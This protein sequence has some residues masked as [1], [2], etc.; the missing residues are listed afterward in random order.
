MKAK[1]DK[2]MLIKHRFWI[3]LGITVPLVLGAVFVLITTVS[4]EID[5]YRKKAE[6]MHNELRKS[7][8]QA[9]P[10]V[11]EV[12][13]KI[14]RDW[15]T[16]ETN[17]HK[18]AFDAQAH[19][20]TW[21]LAVED[22]FD[23]QNGRFAVDVKIADKAPGAKDSWPADSDELYH[24]MVQSNDEDFI[25]VDGRNGLWKFYRTFN[26]KLSS[27]QGGDKQPQ[28]FHIGTGK[29]VTVTYYKS[30]YFYD[31]LTDNER[32]VYAGSYKTQIHPILQIVDPVDTKGN[33]TVQFNGWLYRPD[34][35][36]PPNSK[37]FTYVPQDWNID[38]FIYEEAWMAQEDLWI[39]RELFRMI[40]AANDDV[41]I[42]K[43]A[44][45]EGKKPALFTNPNFELKF[46][47][48]EDGRF[49][50]TAKN[51]L[52]RRQ[53]LDVHFRVKF[54]KSP[55]LDLSSETIL[56]DGEPLD[57]AGGKRASITKEIPLEPGRIQRTG[58]YG[59]EQVLT[60]ETAPV[61]RIDHVAIGL[62]AGQIAH[63]HK[64][65]PQGSK[66][67]RKEEKKEEAQVDGPMG[68]LPM[69][70][71]S[72]FGAGGEQGQAQVKL[73]VNGV[74]FDRYLEVS[75]QSR[76]LPVGLSLIVDQDHIGRV[77]TAFN[78]SKLRF[79]TMQVLLNRYPGSMRPQL[80]G[81][82]GD[83]GGNFNEDDVTPMLPMGNVPSNVPMIGPRGYGSSLGPMGGGSAIGP[84]RGGSSLGPPKGGSSLGPP[85]G[86]SGGGQPLM[87][88]AP[89]FG[90]GNQGL[91]AGA[92]AFLA[93]NE[94]LENNVEVVI[95]GIV[96]LY[97][98]YPKRK[99][100]VS[101]A[102]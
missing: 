3:L 79:L 11:L 63:S 78:N 14:A 25:V 65:Y 4:A 28:W 38:G 24:G 27:E 15:K 22:R 50:L 62:A 55:N 43:G 95:Y 68:M 82:L 76:R 39:Q 20:F 86:I 47:W 26:V 21:P 87:P 84:P 91:G 32:R 67:F 64:S 102:K 93:G 12:R 13:E 53:K 85:R 92:A 51:L 70:G 66:P 61:R 88:M 40:R 97:E 54:N 81:N 35:N 31:R 59:V 83:G 29:F 5:S 94:E 46:Q 77:L 34:L 23:F 74:L 16:Q 101:D 80:V 36:P 41:A 72:K 75:E 6:G 100:Q 44:P 17:V 7:S 99:I 73:G 52:P 98:R 90:G 69:A 19:L 33:G 42:C 89:A 8:P 1:F 45:V 18:I 2:D 37:F 30:R 9:G 96:T 57:P 71:S 49:M 60:W 48:E 56:L 58:I 10:Q